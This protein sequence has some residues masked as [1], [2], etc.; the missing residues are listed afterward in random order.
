[1]GGTIGVKTIPGQGSTFWVR[2]PSTRAGLSVVR[3]ITTEHPYVGNRSPQA[4]CTLLYIEDNPSNQHLVEHLLVP[5]PQVKLL[6]AG[7]GE[8]GLAMA[9]QHRPD[10]ILLDLSPAGSARLGSARQAAVGRSDAAYPRRGRQR[11]RHGGDGPSACHAGRCAGLSAHAVEHR[12]PVPPPAA[13]GRAGRQ[14]RT[15]GYQFGGVRRTSFPIPHD[16]VRWLQRD[17]NPDRGRRGTPTSALLQYILT[18]AGY[19]RTALRVGFPA[20]DG[21]CSTSSSP[22]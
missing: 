21:G 18:A 20:G 17:E 7:R 19:T 11:R 1:M 5:C 6:C 16:C 13:G 12:R 4:A 10:L 8:E 9:R 14:A 22:T 3:E 15:A 2:L